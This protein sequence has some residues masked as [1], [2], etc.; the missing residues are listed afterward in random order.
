[1]KSIAASAVL[2]VSLAIPVSASGSPLPECHRGQP[3][4]VHV[5]CATTTT[6]V[7]GSTTTTS[8]APTTTPT[9]TTIPGNIPTDCSVDVTAQL[10]AWLG[11]FPAGATATLAAGGCYRVDGTLELSGRTLTIEGNG[12]TLRATTTGAARRAHLRFTGGSI[13]VRNLTIDSVAPGGHVDALQYQHGID[14]RGVAGVNIANVVVSDVYGDCVYVGLG[15][16]GSTWTSDVSISGLTCRNNGR[17]GVAVTAGR[18]VTVSGSLFDRVGLIGVDLEPNGVA[19]ATGIRVLANT[20]TT[21]RKWW[22]AALGYSG[23]GAMSDIILDGNQVV[24]ASLCVKVEPLASQRISNVTITDNTGDTAA[25]YNSNGS[26]IDVYRVDGLTV[27][28]NS[29]PGL[30]ADQVFVSATDSSQVHVSGNSFPG[31]G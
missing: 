14:L 15:Y 19:G 31:G 12:A 30:A 6:G 20:F 13:T 23:G 28:G 24:G 2:A 22:F 7:A 16:D 25:N 29:Q 5:N 1:V 26:V 10:R 3:H 4:G 17:Q 9:T 27:T 18:N 11:S 21:G 8:I